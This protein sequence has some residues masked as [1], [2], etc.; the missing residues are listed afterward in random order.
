MTGGRPEAVD[1]A[2]LA[3]LA[4]EDAAG[5]PTLEQARAEY[6]Q[7]AVALGG[8]PAEVADVRDLVAGAVPVRAYRG[9]GADPA[10]APA[11]VW[12]H[13]GGWVL[14]DL[15]GFDRVARQLANAGRCVCVSADYRLAPEHPFPAATEDAHA[16]VAWATGAGAAVLGVDPAR[17]AVGGDSAGGLLAA[18]AALAAR[19][20]VTA[21]LLVYPALD[22]L[23]R[24]ASHV[25]LAD[26]PLLTA[27]A[28][29]GFW[30]AFRGA[31]AVDDP[32]L[33]VLRGELRGAP[34]ARIAV[35]AHDPLR[36]DGLRYAELLAQAGVEAA[37]R[38]YPT[39]THGF[40]RWGAIVR[41][42]GDVIAW[43]A[44]GLGTAAG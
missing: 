35:A 41:E 30:D 16:V 2:I 27:A 13:G 28:M 1:P 7:T 37:T 9:L 38:V 42:A 10:A 21:Q 4:Q 17:V 33:D 29:R 23:A 5:E 14:G 32:A 3:V 36:D 20:Q 34:P 18:S 6:L 11:L 31:R 40:L 26:A 44:S 8:A 39:M 24:G 25:D 22:P 43:L 19:E 15:D 12:F